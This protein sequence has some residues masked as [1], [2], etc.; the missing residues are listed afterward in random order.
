M[1]GHYDVNESEIDSM[2]QEDSFMGREAINMGISIV[3]P[4]VKVREVIHQEK[5]MNARKNI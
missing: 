2:I 4:A 5:L 1:H 3:I